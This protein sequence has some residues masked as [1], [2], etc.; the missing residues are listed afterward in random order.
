MKWKTGLC[1][2][3]KE[4]DILLDPILLHESHQGRCDAP[5]CCKIHGVLSLT[6]NFAPVWGA[7]LYQLMLWKRVA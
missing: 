2:G 5:F 1:D 7:G 3:K 4:E 6:A